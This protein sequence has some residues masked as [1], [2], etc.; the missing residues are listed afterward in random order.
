MN[1]FYIYNEYGDDHC[2]FRAASRLTYGAPDH[3]KEIRETIYDYI[4][5]RYDEFSDFILGDI[6]DCID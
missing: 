6:N 3:H 4:A 2:L 5:T 1:L